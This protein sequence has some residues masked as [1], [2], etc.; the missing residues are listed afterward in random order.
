MLF[1]VIDIDEGETLGIIDVPNEALV[2]DLERE[3]REHDLR[4]E[5]VPAPKV[6]KSVVDFRR[7]FTPDE[8]E[9]IL[10]QVA[11][12][13][14]RCGWTIAVGEDARWWTARN[15]VTHPGCDPK[16]TEATP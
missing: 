4:I 13:C 8:S 11:M 7:L 1:N 10:M 12:P 14:S 9:G 3:C 15:V 5:P 2:A 6:V 16:D